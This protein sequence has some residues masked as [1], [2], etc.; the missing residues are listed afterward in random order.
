L[1]ESE[2]IF[3]LFFLYSQKIKSFEHPPSGTFFAY[4]KSMKVK[5]YF[6][7][8]MIERWEPIMD[9][10]GCVMGVR[11][12]YYGSDPKVIYMLPE[13]SFF[14]L[15]AQLSQ[16]REAVVVK[17]FSSMWKTM[18]YVVVRH[19][20]KPYL[21]LKVKRM[22]SG[23]YKNSVMETERWIPGF[24]ELLEEANKEETPEKAE[25]KFWKLVRKFYAREP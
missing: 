21:R 12:F 16:Y 4:L 17:D 2:K 20:N 19:E 1:L 8:K 14:K 6:R 3:S 24:H 10:Y 11:R 22:K 13:Y 23:I 7:G 25:E 9:P 15:N 18:L 5:I